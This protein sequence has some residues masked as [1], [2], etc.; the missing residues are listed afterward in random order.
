MYGCNRSINC[1]DWHCLSHV[2][3]QEF[4]QALVSLGI[5]SK[6]TKR[7]A[8]GGLNMRITDPGQLLTEDQRVALA[9][10]LSEAGQT[11]SVTRRPRGGIW[12]GMKLA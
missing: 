10:V 3:A 1:C 8:G 6:I 5:M 9:K 12:S 4:E 2:T 11:R 7:R